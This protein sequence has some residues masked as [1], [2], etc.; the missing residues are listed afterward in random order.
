MTALPDNPTGADLVD[1]LRA[2]AAA[3]GQTPTA[4]FRKLSDQPHRW[5]SHIAGTRT[6]RPHTVQRVRAVLADNDAP[7]APQNALTPLQEKV[8]AAIEAA[9]NS[10]LACPANKLLASRF[11]VS[12]TAIVNAVARLE[13]LRLI[14]VERF[15]S[16][17][18]VT[19]TATGRATRHV[20]TEAPHFTRRQPAGA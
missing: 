16:A 18:R 14:A 2:H 12:G 6:P 19:I 20:G 1:A 17:R 7:P 11:Q 5:A 10:R 15:G 9:A 3:T 8:L 13:D 4:I